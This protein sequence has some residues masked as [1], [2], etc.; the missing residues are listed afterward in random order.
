MADTCA[1]GNN[2]VWFGAKAP[3]NEPVLYRSEAQVTW[4]LPATNDTCN[5]GSRPGGADRSAW[6]RKSWRGAPKAAT[7]RGW[8]N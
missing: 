7:T 1:K 6:A 2:D 3:R 4:D 8:G 5:S